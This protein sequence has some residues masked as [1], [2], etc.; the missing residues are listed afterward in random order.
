MFHLYESALK[1]KS[2]RSVMFKE[3]H[4]N[5]VI[6]RVQFYEQIFNE[7]GLVTNNII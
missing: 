3:V 6:K 1:E 2:Q 7:G 5:V 4:R